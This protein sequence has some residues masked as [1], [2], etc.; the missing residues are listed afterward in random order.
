M[1]KLSLEIVTFKDTLTIYITVIPETTPDKK[2]FSRIFYII[3]Q[4][5]EYAADED[6]AIVSENNWQKAKEKINRDL[7]ASKTTP[8]DEK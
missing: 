6:R 7:I 2:K 3:N 8:F 4:C 1:K 5:L